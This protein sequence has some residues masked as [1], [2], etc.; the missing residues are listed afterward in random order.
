MTEPAIRVAGAADADTIL[1]F[2]RRLYAQDGLPFD[3]AEARRTLAGILQDRSLGR[4]WIIGE[5]EDPIGY[6]ILTLGYSLE[7]RGRDAFVDELFVRE[8]RRRRGIGRKA[9]QV[10]EQAC[11]ELEVRAL[12]LEVERPN[13]AARGLYRKLGFVDH[14]RI[15]MTKFIGA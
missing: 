5:G 12:H 13:T 8:D 6:M 4:V 3:E 11:R 10:M 2:M 1:G 7:Y 15:L 14:D 9:M